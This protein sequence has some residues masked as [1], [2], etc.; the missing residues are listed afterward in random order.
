MIIETRLIISLTSLACSLFWGPGITNM[1][2]RWNSL[3]CQLSIRKVSTLDYHALGH[4][5]VMN[6][7]SDVCPT[8]ATGRNY[9][10]ACLSLHRERL[11]YC[12]KRHIMTRTLENSTP[13]Q[14]RIG[15]GVTNGL[16]SGVKLTPKENVNEKE[17]QRT[18]GEF[19]QTWLQ[20]CFMVF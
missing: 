19:I 14:R 7:S 17:W 10:N 2:W 4:L 11:Q 3:R 18:R 8:E 9:N 6:G 13:L 5:H 16:A 1:F 15:S 20:V 12:W